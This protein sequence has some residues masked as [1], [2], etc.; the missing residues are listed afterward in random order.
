M[1]IHPRIARLV[2]PVL[3][4]VCGAACSPDSGEVPAGVFIVG[5]V[6]EPK[7]LDPA[8]VTAV[9]DFRIL[10]NLYE[11]LLVREPPDRGIGK[12]HFE[13][14]RDSPGQWQVGIAGHDLHCRGPYISCAS[15]I[16]R[17]RL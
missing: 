2:L 9:N 13:I 11:D 12:R 7:S 3:L 15:G 4:L 14:G 16:S 17:A 8:T 10:V 1:T 6:A 5:Q